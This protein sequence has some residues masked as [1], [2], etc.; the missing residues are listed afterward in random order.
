LSSLLNKILL[1]LR[2][3]LLPIYS[4]LLNHLLK[5]LPR[6]ISAQALTSLLA[7]L[8]ALFKHLL[9]PELDSGLLESTW[10]SLRGTL[11]DC[12]PEVQRAVAEVWGLTLRL[13]KLDARKRSALFMVKSMSGIEDACAWM[14]VLA[15]KVRG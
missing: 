14:L 9:V 5:L 13:M 15:C 7:S 4:H 2:T 1:D 3:T 10:T 8:S 11:Q 6:S 12:I